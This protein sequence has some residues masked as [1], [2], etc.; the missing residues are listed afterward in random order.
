MSDE[1]PRTP[2]LELE[3]QERKARHW[4]ELLAALDALARLAGG[5][6]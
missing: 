2:G 6:A 4:G 1:T 5:G 3:D